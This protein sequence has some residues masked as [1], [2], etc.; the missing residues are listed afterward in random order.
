MNHF[1]G[2]NFQPSC[3]KKKGT[4]KPQQSCLENIPFLQVTWWECSLGTWL[5]LPS[6]PSPLLLGDL[7]SQFL[8]KG[9][10]M[11]EFCTYINLFYN[12]STIL[13]NFFQLFIHYVNFHPYY[14]TFHNEK[15]KE[16]FAYY[17]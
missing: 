13:Y 11:N 14:Q 3:S 12:L 6:L 16:N 5:G 1:F 4:W 7:G 17:G 2:Q 8:G 10:A 15:L 9:Y